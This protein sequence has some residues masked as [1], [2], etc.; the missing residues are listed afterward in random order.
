MLSLAGKEQLLDQPKKSP[1]FTPLQELQKLKNS[2]EPVRKDS[3]KKFTAVK[4]E[5]KKEAIHLLKNQS[6]HLNPHL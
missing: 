2:V 6:L 4:V 1:A 5:Q 3:Q